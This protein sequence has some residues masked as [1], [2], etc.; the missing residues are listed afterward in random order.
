MNGYRKFRIGC[1]MVVAIALIASLSYRHS[2]T[3]VIT[4]CGL[5]QSLIDHEKVHMI[6]LR[7][8]SGNTVAIKDVKYEL[9]GKNKR[10]VLPRPS[11]VKYRIEVIGIPWIQM[12]NAMKIQKIK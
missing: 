9:F 1:M 11:K 4:Y 3:G 6:K 8:S 5:K 10:L 7:T 12:P 2:Y